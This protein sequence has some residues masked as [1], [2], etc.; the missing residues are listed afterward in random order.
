MRPEVPVLGSVFFRSRRRILVYDKSLTAVDQGLCLFVGKPART[1]IEDAKMTHYVSS[2]Q[3]IW[4]KS[5][6]GNVYICPA[7]LD[8]SPNDMTEQELRQHCLDDSDRPDNY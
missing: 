2:N 6:S 4:I 7:N 8:K 1:L 5:D 3:R